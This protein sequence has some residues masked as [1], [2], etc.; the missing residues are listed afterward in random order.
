MSP[1]LGGP[2]VSPKSSRGI[3][4]SFLRN[5]VPLNSS[6][7]LS[8]KDSDPPFVSYEIYHYLFPI[9][10]Y[11]YKDLITGTE[12][13]TN[14]TLF[15]FPSLQGY[16]IVNK[17]R[18]KRGYPCSRHPSLT[19]SLESKRMKALC[20]YNLWTIG[21]PNKM[22]DVCIVTRFVSKYFKCIP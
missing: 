13:Q 6:A 4:P 12:K 15:Q 5:K 9:D 1:Y 11:D 17:H 19:S 16:T 18:V 14:K 10:P 20:K 2:F 8:T 22:Y 3:H 21:V 7:K